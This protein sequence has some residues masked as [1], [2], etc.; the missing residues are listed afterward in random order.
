MIQNK[1]FQH[2]DYDKVKHLFGLI[3][4]KFDV[5]AFHHHVRNKVL[6][7]ALAVF[8]DKLE[9]K[10]NL[11]KV[12]NEMKE[13]KYI[14][15]KGLSETGVLLRNHSNIKQFSKDWSRCI[16][17]CRRDQIS[18]DYLILKNKLKLA[19]GTFKEKMNMISFLN[20]EGFAAINYFQKKRPL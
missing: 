17:I 7:E 12:I 11:L 20:A 4:K 8:K 15:N 9:T 16:K 19:R 1:K 2:W 14:D 13:N 10:E 3:E 6:D 18:F 5:V